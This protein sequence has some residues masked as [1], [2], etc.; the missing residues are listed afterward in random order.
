M[1][2]KVCDNGIIINSFRNDDYILI[3]TPYLTNNSFYGRSIMKQIRDYTPNIINDTR[4]SKL[5][6]DSGKNINNLIPN[7]PIQIIDIY[8]DIFSK[9]KTDI[10]ECHNGIIQFSSS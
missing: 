6:V 8:G 1:V 9:S 3:S 5:V 10:L 2:L 7:S 4:G